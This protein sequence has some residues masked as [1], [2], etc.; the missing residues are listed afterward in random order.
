MIDGSF[1]RDERTLEK[2]R[3]LAQ[4]RRLT[5]YCGAGVTIDRTTL[6]W[7]DLVRHIVSDSAPVDAARNVTT[8]DI[9][10]EDPRSATE[11]NA[12][13]DPRDPQL[14]GAVERLIDSREL[15]PNALASLA[16]ELVRATGE[17]EDE[18]LASRLK[19]LLY[20]R[21]GWANGR[22]L[23]NIALLAVQAA[24]YDVPVTILTTNYDVYIEEQIDD[25]INRYFSHRAMQ[26]HAPTL[27]HHVLSDE[28]PPLDAVDGI[29]LVYLHGRVDENGKV[30]G[31]IVFSEN[32]Y[33]GNRARSERALREILEK[34]GG[35][36]TVGTSLSDDPLIQALTATKGL[37]A[38]QRVALLTVPEKLLDQARDGVTE[39]EI[40][41][42]LALRGR[43]LGL[44]MLH[45]ASHHQIAQFVE[46]VRVRML[47]ERNDARGDEDASAAGY[48][49][50]LAD[51]WEAWHGSASRP[52]WIYKCLRMG[53]RDLNE[54]LEPL[55]AKPEHAGEVRRL[56][57]WVR[58]APSENRTLTLVG[59][60][61][62][63]IMDEA[64]RRAESTATRRP[65]AIA[66]IRAFQEGKPVRTALTNL[67]YSVDASRWKSFFAV[68]I[69]VEGEVVVGRD[70][71]SVVGTVP[72]AVIVLA[73]TGTPF[74]PVD[75]REGRGTTHPGSAP[76]GR[77]GQSVFY[78]DGLAKDD[79]GRIIA[80]LIGVGRSIVDGR[81]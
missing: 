14:R 1:L 78:D 12:K 69:F 6:G 41:S 64:T 60:S 23:S 52:K 63:P 59:T 66:A 33:S 62:G 47:L 37:D 19:S 56:E 32:S 34:D 18:M 75:V 74:P 67:G 46:E 40:L 13:S 68:P 28:G 35:F 21:T 70:K 57:I 48:A 42:A 20:D 72:V 80:F 81:G 50:R 26:R 76:R 45:P 58:W 65:S 54:I 9:G 38:G 43:H 10:S 4:S 29:D 30:A 5:I 11:D 36:L 25:T 39:P 22:L 71:T 77:T 51:W 3:T 8:A 2:V 27:R 44:T 31:H 49:A 53:L 17:D 15:P 61:A 16:R 24:V 73:G 55:I 7:F 79:F